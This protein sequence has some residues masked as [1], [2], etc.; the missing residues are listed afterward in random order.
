MAG[1][2]DAT[3]AGIKVLVFVLF[4]KISLTERWLQLSKLQQARRQDLN[5]NL[6]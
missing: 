6:L 1:C 5:A 3:F 2:I 4:I